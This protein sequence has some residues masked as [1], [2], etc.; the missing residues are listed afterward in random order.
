M[1]GDGAGGDDWGGGGGR[2]ASRARGQEETGKTKK[3]IVGWLSPSVRTV[4][5]Y[6]FACT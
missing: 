5:R 2:R 6:D 4:P 1:T 3:E